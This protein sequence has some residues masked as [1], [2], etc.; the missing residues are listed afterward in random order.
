[1]EAPRILVVDDRFDT[2]YYLKYLF[3]EHG[4]VVREASHGEEAIGLAQREAPVCVVTDILMPV[5]DGYALCRAWCSD[6]ALQHIPLIVYSCTYS[7]PEDRELA[8]RLGARRYLIAPMAPDALLAE[9]QAVLDEGPVIAARAPLRNETEFLQLYN[10]RLVSRLEENMRALD[11]ANRELR[12][13]QMHS[14]AVLNSVEDALISLDSGGRFVEWNLAAEKIFGYSKPQILGQSHRL[15]LLDGQDG[16]GDRLLDEAREHGSVRA[17][18][19]RKAR[20]GSGRMVKIAMS[21]LGPE[22]GYAAAIHDLTSHLRAQTALETAEKRLSRLLRLSPAVFY[23]LRVGPDGATV[24]VWASDSITRLWGYSTVEVLQPDWWACHLHPEDREAAEA[25]MAGLVAKGRLVHEYRLRTALGEYVW[26]RDELSYFDGD[27][28]TAGEIVGVWLDISESRRASEERASL[29]AQLHQSQKLEAVGQLAGGVAHDFNNMLTVVLGHTGSLAARLKGSDALLRPVLEIRKA[30]E[31]AAAL[32]RRLLAFARHQIVHPQVVDLNEVVGGFRDMLRR[33]IPEDIAIELI[34]GRPLGV[35]LLDPVQVEQILLNLAVNARDA[36]PDGGTLT[37]ETGNSASLDDADDAGMVMLAV[38]DTGVGMEPEI[39]ARIFEPFFT[40]KLEGGGTGLGLATV[41]DI[42]RQSGGRVEVRTTPGEGSRFE[43]HFP[44]TSVSAAE[45]TE[46]TAPSRAR[47][48]TKPSGATILV[49]E[50]EPLVRELTTQLLAEAG[51]RVL[52]ASR[53]AQALTVFEANAAQIGLVLSDVVLPDMSG[54]L[55][56]KRLAE[57]APGLGAI[58]MSGY[59]PMA[60]AD[61]RAPA[62]Y[63]HFL[64]K[65]FGSEELLAAVQSSLARTGLEPAEAREAEA[66]GSAAAVPDAPAPSRSPPAASDSAPRSA[67]PHREANDSFAMGITHELGNRL[68]A[69]R[70]RSSNA[71]RL[72]SDSALVEKLDELDRGMAEVSTLVRDLAAFVSGSP[73]AA[74]CFELP[75]LLK[76]IQSILVRVLAPRRLHMA[77]APGL[78][79]LTM[80]RTALQRLLIML[81]VQAREATVGS[82]RIELRGEATVEE[83][84]R[85]LCGDHTLSPGRYV[86]IHLG[87]PGAGLAAES[88]RSCFALARENGLFVDFVH[89]AQDTTVSLLRPFP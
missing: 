4:Y 54:P 38:S 14:R 47:P 3:E 9:V 81:A 75:V 15:L 27:S 50:D 77:V 5:M 68:L 62:P 42:A 64:A 66:E 88:L 2:R 84:A 40:T 24:P 19:R 60:Q 28:D 39:R 33:L 59:A 11:Q 70:L 1:M 51:Y 83:G 79:L 20:D 46:P 71:R 49:V 55:L 72:A 63:Q 44:C 23:S 57:Q 52:E 69:L 18:C 76:E 78:P 13:A 32:T 17:T 7:Q 87:V 8:L 73:R 10:K 34:L 21:Y 43:V 48:R 16:E 41:V 30:G 25:A 29:A 80:D 53:A 31:R 89:R 26:V 22:L 82:D 86:A 12:Q 37:I 36:M 74:T 85:P 67:T 58:L 35:T 6:P 45:S 61:A 56:I 65:P